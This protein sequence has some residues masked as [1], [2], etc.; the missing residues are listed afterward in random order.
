M[1]GSADQLRVILKKANR[2]IAGT[3]KQPSDAACRM[4]VVHGQP[5]PARASAATQA[6]HPALKG[7]HV[8][9][10]S[11]GYAVLPVVLSTATPVRVP[12]SV[13]LIRPSP[14]AL[15]AGRAVPEASLSRHAPNKLKVV[16]SFSALRAGADF[17]VVHFR[18]LW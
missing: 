17:F 12:F 8:L 5:H 10:V 7:F 15:Y 1:R 9:K 3:T 13:E 18:S 2:L 16:L 4:T 6:A 14:V 11:Y